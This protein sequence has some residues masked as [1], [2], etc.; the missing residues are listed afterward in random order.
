MDCVW[1]TRAIL[2]TLFVTGCAAMPPRIQATRKQQNDWHYPCIV[3][4]H[5]ASYTGD[6][7]DIDNAVQNAVRKINRSAGRIV[8]VYAGRRNETE[9]QGVS[10]VYRVDEP[11]DWDDGV[12]GSVTPVYSQRRKC[13]DHWV[14][15]I[16]STGVDTAPVI[17]HELGHVIGLPHTQKGIMAPVLLP[18]QRAIVTSIERRWIQR[19]AW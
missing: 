2:F 13:I 18:G 10:V 11:D 9:R 15:R 5:V 16:G 8:L 6:K 17:L 3:P 14:V 4:Q 7:A 19:T 12:G 1:M